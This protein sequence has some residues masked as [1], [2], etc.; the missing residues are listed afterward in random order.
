MLSPTCLRHH[1]SVYCPPRDL[2]CVCVCVCVV[3]S[4]VFLCHNACLDV[5]CGDNMLCGRHTN[6]WFLEYSPPRPANGLLWLFVFAGFLHFRHARML[7]DA[8]W[9]PAYVQRTTIATAQLMAIGAVVA[10]VVVF[11]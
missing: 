5:L 4:C 10:V 8:L 6:Y 11:A 9:W 3:C 7:L 2:V 1:H